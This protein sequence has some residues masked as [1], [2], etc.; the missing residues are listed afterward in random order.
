MCDRG[1]EEDDG[2]T[3]IYV[4]ESSHRKAEVTGVYFGTADGKI[5]GE[6]GSVSS[7]ELS[8]EAEQYVNVP[9]F[10]QMEFSGS[11]KIVSNNE[12]KM[13]GKPLMRGRLRLRALL[14]RIKK[15]KRRDRRR[16]LLYDQTEWSN[17]RR[18]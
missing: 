17:S 5:L 14:K 3:G 4:N 15:P 1:G 8:A 11:F 7:V 10:S 16:W 18:V 6:L 12:R 13:R 9:A 2:M